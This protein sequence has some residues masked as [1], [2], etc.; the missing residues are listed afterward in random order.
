MR[1]TTTYGGF[2]MAQFDISK[3]R[4]NDR[5]I[6]GGA[7]LLLILSFLP[8]FSVSSSAPGGFG[9]GGSTNLWGAYGWNKVALVLALIAGA[10]VLARLMGALDAVQLPVG[11][12]LVTLVV[13][14]LASLIFLLRFLTAFESQSL[15]GGKISAH[16]AFGWYLGLLVSLAMTYFAFLN[17]KSSGEELPSKPAS[18][19]PV[20]G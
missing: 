15:L 7:V 10:I 3:V 11:I 19:P 16:P 9:G 14:G 18:T 8:W 2:M 4:G 12:N 6:A 13:S 17:F 20:E 5:F 1:A